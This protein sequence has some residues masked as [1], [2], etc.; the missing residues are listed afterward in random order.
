MTTVT[1]PAHPQLDHKLIGNIGGTFIVPSYQRGYRWDTEDVKRLLDDIWAC[2][3]KDYSLQPIVVK[4]ESSDQNTFWELIDGQQRLT[5]L[6]L[7]FLYMKRAGLQNAAPPYD[8][9]Y[10]TRPGSQYYLK[11]IDPNEHQDNI[12]NLHLYNAYESIRNWFD[13]HGQRRQLVA[14]K[15]YGYL[16]DNVRVIWYEP[17]TMSNDNNKKDSI[18][19]FTRLNMGRIP[20]TD[21]ELI[22]A[23]LLSEV[24]KKQPD[25]A[26]E[27]AAQWD[28][29]END[30]H[31]P[32]IWAFIASENANV[33][34]EIYPT[35]I[36]LLLDTLADEKDGKPNGK[37]P[38]YYTFDTLRKYIENDTSDSKSTFWDEVV[39][40]H[41]LIMGWFRNP[42]L[43]NKIG[44]LVFTGS[45]FGDL[46]KKS[47][48]RKKQFEISLID[49]IRSK[50]NIQ[51]KGLL[52][53]TYS[54][55]NDHTKLL[56]L[57][58][59][60]NVETVTSIKQ[61]F[62]FRLHIGKTWSLEHIHAQ[63]AEMLVKRDQWKAWLE[64]HKLALSVFSTKNLHNGLV[65]EIDSALQ[66]ID[67]AINFGSKFQDISARV[68]DVFS[69]QK[70]THDEHSICNLALLSQ[71]D[72]SSLSNAVFEVK[73]QNILKIDRNGGYIPECTRN[74]FL[75]Y[76]TCE[77]AQQIHFWGPQD[78]ENYYEA[79]VSTLN[80]YL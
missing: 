24:R 32:D 70:S 27:I 79:I 23:L 25:R 13:I 33:N 43:Y 22:K 6:Y 47:N 18:A 12:D 61:R 49:G 72:N 20:L 7:I 73:R 62:P 60:M 59:L 2:G 52:D 17:P 39:K 37:R 69:A 26:Q 8:I 28:R 3:G 30:L 51:K 1:Q 58:L 11:T 5:T 56:N 57:L 63:N 44:F 54:D 68:I 76:Y 36:N 14:N 74:V 29:I 21:A 53:L 64:A 77:D 71:N 41:S 67:T 80:N 15:F 50:I 4:K 46:V 40:L 31:D 16:F 48:V 66:T 55:N 34:A 42:N 75:K 38:R 78:K 45:S 9:H 35:R 19:L 10:Q 65:Q